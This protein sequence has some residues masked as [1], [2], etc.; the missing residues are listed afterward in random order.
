MRARGATITETSGPAQPLMNYER[1]GLEGRS[2][3]EQSAVMLAWLLLASL[4]GLIAWGATPAY[5]DWSGWRYVLFGLGVA[6]VL[7]GGLVFMSVVAL[8]VAGWWS[9]HNRR[10]LAF[11]L[12][13]QAREAAGGLVTQRVTDMWEFD[14]DVPLHISALI[15]TMHLAVEARRAR[16]DTR[17]PWA[18]A[19]LQG[20]ML[21]GGKKLLEM[22]EWEAREAGR[23]L[24]LLGLV[25]GRSERN[26][27]EWVPAT[28]DDAFDIAGRNLH[29]ALSAP[30]EQ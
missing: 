29:R 14:A 30:R 28:L 17:A 20:P 27:G 11:E 21:W 9:V 19:N 8:M 4:G 3:L 5:G 23:V 13:I 24:Q 2:A 22:S 18:V 12:D 10:H 1:G 15:L 6:L 25:R 26:A 7:T 16:G